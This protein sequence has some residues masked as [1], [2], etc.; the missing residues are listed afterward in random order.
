M[1][2]YEF[3]KMDTLIVCEIKDSKELVYQSNFY[4]IHDVIKNNITDNVTLLFHISGD[5]FDKIIKKTLNSL[6]KELVIHENVDNFDLFD[7]LFFNYIL[8]EDTKK[9]VF[10]QN[11]LEDFIRVYRNFVKGL[12]T[13]RHDTIKHKTFHVK[14]RRIS[15]KQLDAMQ[16]DFT[17]WAVE[18]D[19]NKGDDDDE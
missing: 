14:Q 15:R 10:Q 13:Y 12:K 17:K 4:Q 3:I 7:F 2:E 11:N 18:T 6:E 19:A 1:K 9:E 8:E 5:G 16:M